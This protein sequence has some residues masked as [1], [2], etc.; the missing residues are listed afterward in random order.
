MFLNS[1]RAGPADPG[2]DFWFSAL[3]GGGG[4]T[5]TQSGAIVTSDSAMRLSTVYKCIKVIAETI[6]MLPMH[7]YRNSAGEQR[8]RVRDHPIAHLL[9]VRPNAWQTPMQFRSMLEAHRSMRGNGYARIV[10]GSN[11]DPEALIPLH[12]DRVAPEIATNGLPRY[13]VKNAQGISEGPPL[14]QGE[15]LHLTGLSLDGYVG[16]NPIQAE[17]EAIGSAIS[18]RDFGSRFWNND[19]RPPFWIKMP[20]PA[21]FKDA[22]A[23]QNF[24]DDWQAK[25]G[26]SN[27]GRPA[28]LDRGMEIH[29][30]GLSNADSQ[31]IEA[32]KY[33]DVDLC[34]LWRMPPHK[35][36]ILDRATWGNIEQ[37]NIEFVTDCLL[38][39]AVSWEQTIS[40]DLIIDDDLFVELLME[41]LLRG[42]T[43]TRYDA[44]GKAIQDGWLTRNEIRR[45]ENKNP[46]PGLDE[47]LQPLNMTRANALPPPLSDPRRPA[48]AVAL[49]AASVD[50]VV[51]KEIKVLGDLAKTQRSPAE[52]FAGH[53]QFVATVMAVPLTTATAY[54]TTMLESVK[55]LTPANTL[56]ATQEAAWKT[57]QT[58]ALMQLEG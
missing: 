55:A 47:P 10:Y 34:G 57:M 9:S 44:Y 15:I 19:S 2:H 53:A 52:A 17:R 40:R 24:R 7:M 50:R 58:A 28:V 48:R 45:L 35:I 22:E 31:W 49:L 12:P 33:S 41:L 37:Q 11:G 18:A 13:H 30:L 51:R 39:L 27:R 42:D 25:Y 29:E 5:A 54:T 23:A 38:P 4:G 20:A 36:G 3:P 14:V 46:L 26:G 32:R 43:A 56:D 16:M 21:Q 1:L 6:G 8:D